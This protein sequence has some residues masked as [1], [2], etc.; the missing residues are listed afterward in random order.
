MNRTRLNL[1]S[2]ESRENPSGTNLP[3]PY[4]PPPPAGGT[5]PPA[6]SAPPPGGSTSGPYTPPPV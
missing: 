1:T 5:E 4:T 3:G 6:P 2:L